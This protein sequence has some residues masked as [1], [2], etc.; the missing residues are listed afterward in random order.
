MQQQIHTFFF[1]F[2]K[3]RHKLRYRRVSIAIGPLQPIPAIGIDRSE[4]RY[5]VEYIIN[6][7]LKKKIYSGKGLTKRIIGDK[8]SPG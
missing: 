7:V 6:V 2:L 5:S 3:T 8:G 4:T 1:E